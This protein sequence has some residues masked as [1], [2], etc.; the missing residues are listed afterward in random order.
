MITFDADAHAYQLDGRPVPHVTGILREVFGESYWKV[1]EWYLQ[2]GTAVHHAVRLLMEGRLDWNSVDEV[3]E[4]R[5]KAAQKF[6]QDFSKMLEGAKVEVRVASKHGFA[7]T[8]D[9]IAEKIIVDWKGSITPAAEL[10][11]AAYSLGAEET[12]GVK[13]GKGIAV[14]LRDDGTY[15]SKWYELRLARNQFLAA[16][17]IYN[18]KA[19]HGM[20][21]GEAK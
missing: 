7:G 19:K 2:R 3:I 14:E 4:G 1:D 8:A 6:T 10:Q 5:V 13:I 20:L 21:K 17:S 9:V 12:L 11:M 15:R 16:M 18:F